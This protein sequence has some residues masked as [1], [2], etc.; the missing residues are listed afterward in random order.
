MSVRFSSF[1]HGRLADI[2]RLGDLPLGGITRLAQFLE[3][4]FLAQH[5][6][7]ALHTHDAP[8]KRLL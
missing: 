8:A 1:D 7:L 5:G 3:R 2:Q 4:H 6:G